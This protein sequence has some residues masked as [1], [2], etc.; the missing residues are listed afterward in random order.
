VYES[1][2]NG[3]TWYHAS[4]GL[5]HRSV[6]ALEVMDS[7]LVAAVDSKE[8]SGS[9][10]WWLRLPYS[11]LTD[12]I[13]DI[14]QQQADIT[15]VPQ[16]VNDILHIYTT[17][18]P[19]SCTLYTITGRALFTSSNPQQPF[20]FD[21]SLLPSGCYIVTLCTQTGVVSQKILVLH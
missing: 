12:V 14:P 3:I 18:I 21:T 17:A 6:V 9:G 11:P 16:P 2:D 8:V 15:I 5:T 10:V 19:L 13:E 20:L 4:D 1:T 7:I